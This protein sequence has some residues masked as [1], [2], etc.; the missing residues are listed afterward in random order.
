[1]K[2]L[3]SVSSLSKEELRRLTRVL[4]IGF[5]D[6]D[7]NEPGDKGEII[8]AIKKLPSALQ[9]HWLDPWMDLIGRAPA[10]ALCDLHTKLNPYM[11]RYIFELLRCEVITHLECLYW[12][13]SVLH[14]VRLDLVDIKVRDIVYSLGDICYMWT[15]SRRAIQGSPVTYQQNK[16]EAC[17]LARIVNGR[18][19]LQHLRT[20]LLSRTATRRNHRVPTFLPFVEESIAC[21]EGFIDKIH[22][23]SS[24][25]A[26]TMKRQRK[27]AHRA[28]MTSDPVASLKQDLSRTAEGAVVPIGIDPEVLES[29]QKGRQEGGIHGERRTISEQVPKK[30]DSDTDTLAGIVGLY[31]E[32]HPLNWISSPT[33]CA[34]ESQSD[35]SSVT[36]TDESPTHVSPASLTS[37]PDPLLVLSPSTRKQ[38]APMK[39]RVDDSNDGCTIPWTY[40]PTEVKTL[41]GKDRKSMADVSR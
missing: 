23:R 25:L 39:D 34:M 31:N 29:F 8:K 5:I 2:C 33:S 11:I 14:D 27:H 35:L 28:R 37:T 40:F 38:K 15:P 4:S 22:W 26:A 1:M 7:G 20:A 36:Y 17:I 30:Q 41:G 24:T 19:F 16:C 21:H 12:Y 6:P 3:Q 32:P 9:R 18:K 10:V 13:H